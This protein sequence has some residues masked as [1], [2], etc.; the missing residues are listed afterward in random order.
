ATADRGAVALPDWARTPAGSPKVVVAPL[1]PSMLGGAK[2]LAGEGGMGQELA[3]ARGS[4]VHR[5]LEHL[6]QHPVGDWAGIAAALGA[7]DVLAEA[8][9]VI[10]GHAGLF[11]PGTL[12]EVGVTAEIGGRRVLGS[13]DRLV[14]TEAEVLA[15]DFKSNQVVPERAQDVPEGILRQMGAYAAALAQIYPGR[16]IGT[17]IL[18]TQTGRLLHLNPDIVSAALDRALSLD[19]PAPAA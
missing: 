18:W 6:P 12:A 5:L 4:L 16:R 14:V 10:A 7:Q 1:S 15:V 13:I 8:R 2:A 17:A 3:M 9:A 19:V 11:G